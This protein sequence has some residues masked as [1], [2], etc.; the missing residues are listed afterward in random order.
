MQVTVRG[1]VMSP[2]ARP[3]EVR[4]VPDCKQVR[5]LDQI[6]VLEILG[7]DDGE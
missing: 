7:D 4:R 3:D 1:N 5:H 6:G 2:Y